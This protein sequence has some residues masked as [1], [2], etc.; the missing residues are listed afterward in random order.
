[1]PPSSLF[2]RAYAVV[3]TDVLLAAL[4]YTLRA[5][6]GLAIPICVYFFLLWCTAYQAG[7]SDG[8]GSLWRGIVSAVALAVSSLLSYVAE[9]R[10]MT[11]VSHAG[12]KLHRMM[13]GLV[14]NGMLG[15]R[16][17]S[18][19]LN[20]GEVHNLHGVDTGTLEKAPDALLTL[21]LQP[22]EILAIVSLL[23]WFVGA[24][25]GGALLATLL[26]FCIT[27]TAGM[28]AMK[29]D[30]A[31]TQA[32]DERVRHLS[33]FLLG[34]R[35]VKLL[36]WEGQ[37]SKAIL[38]ARGVESKLFSKAGPLTAVVNVSSSNGIDFISV[39][40]LL[41]YVYGQ[42]ATITPPMV[43]TYWVLLAALHGRIFHLP[44][45]ISESREAIEAWRRLSEFLG[46]GGG[47]PGAVVEALAPSTP[48]PGMAVEMS[49]DFAWGKEDSCS[50]KGVSLSIPTGSLV[51][52][53]GPVASGKTTLLMSVLGE[54]NHSGKGSGVMLGK[55]GHGGESLS[56]LPQTPFTLPSTVR[57]NICLGREYNEEWYNT[58]VEACSLGPDFKA[59]SEGDLSH[60]SSTIL[61]GGQ[62]Q[63]VGLARALYG[64]PSIALFDD[65]LSALDVKVGG[66]ILE[67]LLVGKG[68]LL[69]GATRMVVSNSP[70]VIKC[71]DMVVVMGGGKEGGRVLTPTSDTTATTTS[72]SSSSSST[73]STATLFIQGVYQG[74]EEALLKSEFVQSSVQGAFQAPVSVDSVSVPRTPAGGA[75]EGGEGE[76]GGSG[77]S[78]SLLPSSSSSTQPTSTL[79]PPLT[80]VI[81]STVLGSGGVVWFSLAQFSLICE[82]AFV[83][84]S[85]VYLTSWSDNHDPSLVS[86]FFGL[87]GVFVALEFV[88]AF[89]R[90]LVYSHGCRVGQDSLH[91]ALLHRI[92]HAQQ[93]FFDKTS[94][95]TLLNLFSRDLSLCDKGTWYATEYYTLGGMYALIVVFTN[96]F[97]TPYSILALVPLLPPLLWWWWRSQRGGGV[98]TNPPPL[99]T[100]QPENKAEGTAA[101]DEHTA[102]VALVDHLSQ[103]LEGAVVLR[104][105]PG[106]V[107]RA[108][109]THEELWSRFG[110]AS[111]AGHKSNT[112]TVLF[113]NCVGA[114][115]YSVT[116]AL[117]ILLVTLGD[118]GVSAIEGA[119]WVVPNASLT[120]GQA[121]LLLLNA[122]FASYMLQML[123]Q[124]GSAL[125]SL[126]E[127]RGRILAFCS[128]G[129]EIEVECGGGSPAFQWVF[130]YFRGGGQGKKGGGEKDATTSVM[131][132]TPSPL[133]SPWPSVGHLALRGVRLRYAQHLPWVLNGVDLE[134]SPGE[135]V[136]VV[137][138]T[139]AG[140]SSLVAAITRL[141]EVEGGGMV[142]IDGVPLHTLPLSVVRK[143]VCVVTQDPLFF[144]GDLR[145]NLDPFHEFTDTELVEVL[146]VVGFTFSS[147]SPSS[148]P[149]A[150]SPSS[151]VTG[152]ATTPAPQTLDLP[153]GERGAGLSA[154]QCQLV[155]FARALLRKPRVL[156][157]DEATATLDVAAEERLLLALKTSFRGGSSPPPTVLL[158][159]HR[160]SCTALCD[161]VAV[162][163]SGVVIEVGSP[164]ELAGKEGGYFRGLC[165][166]ASEK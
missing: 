147:N 67:A 87:Y 102:K 94:T 65:P 164:S 101:E 74:F 107:G 161:R 124:N 127:A 83:E 17:G 2:S 119:G 15:R 20:S 149:P 28:Q 1:M 5:A 120:S 159:S 38:A 58:V 21:L 54:L 126:A 108:I 109:D 104:A 91:S 47:A 112:S 70:G 85:V 7:A 80:S 143:A 16:A 24:A 14:F 146:R 132:V 110:D 150:S 62:R 64:K 115:Y 118:R 128:P 48:S 79:P 129:G 163:D 153:V 160:L 51:V 27:I 46:Q 39:G 42:G 152:A 84:T 157:L 125:R 61:S 114:L 156:V 25:A 43:F 77:N 50:L 41:V 154:G 4:F 117:I 95:G 11:R 141:V 106:G 82:A 31:R 72:S 130:P 138:R 59:W 32:A 122:A 162:M 18:Q 134:L 155:A 68:A 30:A 78:L 139:G 148:P 92:A 165:E 23:A 93:A 99:T 135:V 55:A 29:L 35:A 71:A 158:I 123:L 9:D 90:Q 140:K 166:K 60:T 6:C 136:C 76:S 96:A 98:A 44:I 100:T 26:N 105:F 103:C 142:E 13:A 8:S 22:L 88:A 151:S 19:T 137:G 57:D 34:M 10:Y 63:R 3:S 121:G 113:F 144:N 131:V 86:F 111:S 40:L 97:F 56:Y 49:G 69:K 66:E 37:F 73:S 89:S 145:S 116:V 52:V 75:G 81:S 33:E 133:P 12:L 36:G 45:A 53:C